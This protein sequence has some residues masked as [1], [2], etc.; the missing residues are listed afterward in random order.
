MPGDI[1]G[2]L[3]LA[4]QQRPARVGEGSA[5]LGREDRTGAWCEDRVEEA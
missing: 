2:L 3:R 4:I 1:S 5:G